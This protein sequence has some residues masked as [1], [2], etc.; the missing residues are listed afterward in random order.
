MF[1]KIAIL[2][3][4]LTIFIGGNLL[5][6]ERPWFGGYVEVN[7]SNSATVEI[8][9]KDIFDNKYPQLEWDNIVTNTYQF[10]FSVELWQPAP[11]TIY[12]EGWAPY[13]C[14]DYDECPANPNVTH[15]LE[16]WLGIEPPGEEDPE[17]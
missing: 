3:I 8:G 2:A 12:A 15:Y 11:V 17:Q 6:S 4:L 7:T 5:S 16:L 13:G 9:Y 10:G 14:H 1:K